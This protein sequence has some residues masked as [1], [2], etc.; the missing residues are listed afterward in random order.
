MESQ[1]SETRRKLLK[2]WLIKNDKRPADL[3]DALGVS[4]AAVNGWKSNQP[5]QDGRWNEIKSFFG[6]TENP[7]NE[8]FRAIG[9]AVTDAQYAS[10]EGAAKKENMSVD[11]FARDAVLEKVASI[12]NPPA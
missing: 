3:A 6:E 11:I 2:I 12:I 7:P 9:F 8:T 5:I 1:Q 4:V 10:I